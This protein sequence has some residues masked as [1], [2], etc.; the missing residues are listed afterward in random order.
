MPHWRGAC[1]ILA[2]FLVAARAHGASADAAS[3]SASELA[4]PVELVNC[5][6]LDRAE[7]LKLLAI[8]FGTLDIR[9][10]PTA[11][12]LRIV[13]EGDSA[14]ATLEPA[15]T[16]SDVALSGTTPSAWPRLLALAASELV[17]ESRARIVTL[18]SPTLPAPA[19]AAPQRASRSASS[20]PSPGSRV[21]W[22]A[23]ATLRRQLRA[24]VTLL[25]P[26]LGLEMGLNRY[27]ALAF[28]AAAE[29]G[30]ERGDLAKVG[31]TS[32]GGTLA[33][34]LRADTGRFEFGA[35]P[36]VFVGALQLSPT[37]TSAGATGHEVRGSWWGPLLTARASAALGAGLFADLEITGGVISKGVLG[38][39][40][41]GSRLVDPGG[42]WL[43]AGLGVGAR[44]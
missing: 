23:G 43:S 4:L 35:G 27:F 34:L 30:S 20:V 37:V 40:S 18:P 21:K 19:R 6:A 26:R 16:S 38:V 32:E 12:R 8:E 42:S 1:L 24:E 44:F 3:A 36:G 5:E 17:I 9:R 33:G 2:G 31:W 15:G 29:V 13:C 11:E 14:R 28:D 25:G 10:Q 22:R 7:L 39:A 41:D